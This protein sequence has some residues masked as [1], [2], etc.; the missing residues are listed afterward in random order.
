MLS[1]KKILLGV[2][3]GIA[4]Y[5][6]TFLVRLF[7][8]AGAEVQV[9]MTPA[10][11][12]FVTPL[13][14]STLSEKPV[15]WSYFDKDDDAGQWHNHVEL[16][17]WA[18]VMVVA[19]ATAHTLAKMAQGQSDNFLMAVLLS[20]KCPV[21]FAPAMDLDMHAHAATQAN[22]ET[23]KQQGLI[24]IPA[25][26]GHLASGLKGKGRMAEPEHIV[27]QMEAHL[28]AQQPLAGK[29][30]CITAGPTYEPLDPVRFLGNRSSGKM[31]IA[32]A[33]SARA[34]G[35]EVTLILGPT[36]LRPV[37]PG[38]KVVPIRTA[39]EML[40]AAQEP[41]ASSQ[42]A[43]FAAAVSDY[44]PK[45]EAPQKRKKDGRAFQLEL[46]E[47]P[48]ILATLAGTK[49]PGQFVIGF[50]LE[51]ENLEASAWEKLRKKNCDALIANSPDEAERGFE[52]DTNEGF[53]LTADGHSRPLKLKSKQALAHEI[54]DTLLDGSYI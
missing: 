53:L 4:A 51:T 3:G 47:N 41:F 50:A 39:Q 46:Q 28:A 20:A 26:E 6:S 45:Q 35:A 15:Y 10:A 29:H 31:G 21:Y 2:T 33:E 13:T 27:A 36:H 8:K 16:A 52:H 44:R 43:I 24:H 22:L 42:V 14:L 37:D 30:V 5:K 40:A 48:D 7:R 23:L 25:E 17:L 11:R 32:L 49:K 54:Y 9:V 34:R 38:I 1:G 19:P 12:D 18:D